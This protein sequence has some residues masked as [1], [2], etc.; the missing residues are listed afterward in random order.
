MVF[1]WQLLKARCLAP[2][3]CR[4]EDEAVGFEGVTPLLQPLFKDNFG[5]VMVRVRVV[6]VVLGPRRPS[7]AGN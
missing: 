5:Y 2:K 6:K 4:E 7:A 1:Y 3:V